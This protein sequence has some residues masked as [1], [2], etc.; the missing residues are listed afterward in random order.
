M[1]QPRGFRT[2]VVVAILCGYGLLIPAIL[3]G[4]EHSTK[5]LA[6]ALRTFDYNVTHGEDQQALRAMLGNQLERRI[7]KANQQSSREWNGL[8]GKEDWDWFRGEKLKSLLSAARRIVEDSAKATPCHITGKLSGEG[9]R[10]QNLLFASDG[11]LWISANLYLPDPLRDSMPGIVISHSHHAPKH[12]GE[13][14]DMGMTWARAGCAV[15]IPDHLGHG[16]RREHPFVTA[17]DYVGKFP[18]S[19]QDYNFR[20]D[21]GMQLCLVGETLIEQL[22]HDLMRGVSVLLQQSGVDAQRIILLGSVAGGGDPAAFAAALD[23]RIACAAVFNF[24]G[25]QPETRFPLPA[26]AESWFNYAGSGSW[27]SS[28]N[29][30]RSAAEGFLPWVI[31]GSIAP[32]KFIYGHEFSWDRER[33]PVWKRLEQIWTWQ[34]ARENLAFTHGGGTIQ[35]NGPDA[36]HCNN[37]GSAHRRLIHIAFQKWF[38]IDV[39][40]EKEY[41]NRRNKQDLLCWTEQWRTKLQPQPLHQVLRSRLEVGTEASPLDRPQMQKFWRSQLGWDEPPGPPPE[42][43]LPLATTMLPDHVTALRGLLPTDQGIQVPV[44]LLIPA[45]EEEKRLPYVVAVASAGKAGFLQHRSED[46]AKLLQSGVVVCLPDVRGCGETSIGADRG[47]HSAA[48]DYSSTELMLGKTLLGQRCR[49]LDCVISWCQSRAELDPKRLM[50]WGDSF[51]PPLEAEATFK[52]PRRIDDR[53][54]ESDP[55]GSLLVLLA[56]LNRD[57]TQAIYLQGGLVD[58]QSMLLSSFVQVPHDCVVPGLHGDADLPRLCGMLAPRALR[59]E[60]L[61]DGVNRLTKPT[62]LEAAYRPTR[63]E[64]ASQ[65]GETEFSVSRERTSPAKWLLEQQGQNRW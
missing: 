18:L 51:T 4:G 44:L 13:L 52:Y 55:L 54:P 32:R 24:G 23:S 61:V 8:K 57:E 49:D 45:R 35:A 6:E 40:T 43:P 12:E 62:D 1:H 56:A 7:G 29:A 19:R 36:T 58:Y 65:K 5:E 11:G 16:E 9:F 34:D 22:A 48:T 20:Y 53:P 10:I 31:V 39:S 21:M 41:T 46:I 37:I 50:L 28:R 3:R 25:P 15:L 38:Q 14:Q 27:E 60:G 2:E 59:L 26:D 17:A 30:P 33:D 64:Y 42:N 63:A 47:Q